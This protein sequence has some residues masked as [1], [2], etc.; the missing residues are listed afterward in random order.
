M[1]TDEWGCP[2]VSEVDL[3]KVIDAA[4][5]HAHTHPTMKSSDYIRALVTAGIMAG[6]DYIDKQRGTNESR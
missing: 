4:M 5:R 3:E 6:I 1:P 2:L